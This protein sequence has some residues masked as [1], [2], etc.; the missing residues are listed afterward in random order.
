MQEIPIVLQFGAVDL[1]P[2]LDQPLLR[3]WQ[4]SAQTLNRVHSED[5]RMVLIVRVERCSMV[6]RAGFDE[7]P[8]NYRETA[9]VPARVSLTSSA[10]L[11]SGCALQ[12]RR[13][14]IAPSAVGC[15]RS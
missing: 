4:A 1:R 6:L 9:R 10:L 5:C 13:S 8:D 14:T 3:L 15:K 11:L 12:P 7:H 2:S